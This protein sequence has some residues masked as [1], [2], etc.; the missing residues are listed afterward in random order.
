MAQVDAQLGT[1]LDGLDRLL[2]GLI[3]GDNLVWQVD[4]AHE[5]APF[6]TPYARLARRRGYR[7]IYFRFARHQALLSAQDGAEVHE[8]RPEAGFE[9]F[10][11]DVHA[12]I[13]S[14]GRGGY[15]VF[16]CLSDLAAD[17]YSDQMLG[18][19]FMLTCPYLYD[20]EAIAYFA[21][22]RGHHSV[23]ATGAISETT[24][25]FL[26]VY[27]HKQEV[28]LHPL[29]VQQRYSPT[30]YTLHVQRGQE[31]L[32]V[33]QSAVISEIMN[34]TVTVPLGSGNTLG[35]WHRAFLRAQEAL[36]GARAGGASGEPAG[37]HFRKLLRMAISRDPRV[38]E[39]LEEYLDLEQV[40]AIGRRMIGTGLIGGKSVGM[41]L[42]RAILERSD[43]AWSAPSGPASAC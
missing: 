15:Y 27:R 37:E 4:A 34:S 19:F 38:L 31:F 7:L 26:D 28:Y 1:G 25:V 17:W 16:D 21:L 2:R 18:N 35:I 32:P 39:L 22:L 41:L 9:Q 36:E 8:L 13:Q 33:T 3:P 23:H 29:K 42:A 10:V 30:M 5:Y 6:V 20:M 24:Q 40:I 43:A 14:V 12:V 11:T